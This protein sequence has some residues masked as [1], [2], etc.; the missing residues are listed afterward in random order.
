AVR[1]PGELETLDAPPDFVA[2][3]EGYS[4]D[5]AVR[6]NQAAVSL[7]RGHA[8]RCIHADVARAARLPRVPAHLAGCAE[9]RRVEAYAPGAALLAGRDAVILVAA[10]HLTARCVGGACGCVDGRIGAGRIG[11]AR[12]GLRS[13]LALTSAA[14]RAA[15]TRA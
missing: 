8:P 7:R 3:G 6:S 14:A 4:D 9:S 11:A 15:D 5:D 1:V 13:I 10:T 2:H 12:F